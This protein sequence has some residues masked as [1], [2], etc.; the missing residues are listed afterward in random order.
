MKHLIRLNLILLA[1]LWGSALMAANKNQISLGSVIR[2]EG[3]VEVLRNPV[4][5]SS[6]E[7]QK[8]VEERGHAIAKFQERY[9]ESHTVQAGSKLFYGDQISTGPDG[10][11]TLLLDDQI[12]LSL[13]A[14]TSTHLTRGYVKDQK[15][16]LVDRWV[17]LISGVIRARVEGEKRPRNT[18]FRTRSIAMGVRGTEFILSSKQG[19]SELVTLEGVVEARRV[20]EQENAAFEKWAQAAI[21]RVPNETES[22]EMTALAELSAGEKSVT[23]PAGKLIEIADPMGAAPSIGF[24]LVEKPPQNGDLIVRDISE[25]D[26]ERLKRISSQFEST[27]RANAKVAKDQVSESKSIPTEFN[28][29]HIVG[30]SAVFSNIAVNLLDQST[31]DLKGQSIG[32][33]YRWSFHR[34]M[35]VGA[36]WTPNLGLNGEMEQLF[37]DAERTELKSVT[38]LGGLRFG[39][40]YPWRVFR[41]GGALN[42]MSISNFDFEVLAVEAKSQRQLKT[43]INPV[44]NL[45]ATYQHQSGYG[46]LMDLGASKLKFIEPFPSGLRADTRAEHSIS[47]IRLGVFRA[48]G[49]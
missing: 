32:F 16:G 6:P 20:S 5:K 3:K 42:L 37:A 13:A 19:R 47:F 39:A 33:E 41:F 8:S 22:S 49:Y 30:I 11:L 26:H 34:Y 1:V 43:E 44:I 40:F 25:N 17:S 48:F 28:R 23:L 36:F 15:S 18:Q 27:D 4:D 21:A 45:A 7:W 9:W 2:T 31:T 10:R 46:V 12:E 24:A 35:D 29:Q 14:N 38:G